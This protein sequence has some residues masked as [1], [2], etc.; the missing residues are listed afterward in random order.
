MRPLILCRERL[1][2][3]LSILDRKGGE[4]SVRDLYRTFGIFEWEVMQAEALG[5]LT[6]TT[7]KPT[8]GRPAVIAKKVSN[9]V[10]AKLPP[11]RWDIPSDISFRH[12]NFVFAYLSTWPPCNATAAYLASFHNA[13]TKAGA[14]ASASR[15]LKHPD[16]KAALAWIRACSDGDFPASEK[17]THPTSAAE[18]RRIF[19]QMGYW[20]QRQL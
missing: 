6:I 11:P 1:L 12:W 16:I 20:R 5:W 8:T 3:I 2:R 17:T 18:M 14:R 19:V 10:A 4:V 15:L 7:V 13:R 9:P